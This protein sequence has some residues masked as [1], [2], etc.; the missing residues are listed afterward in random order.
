MPEMLAVPAAAAALLHPVAL[1]QRQCRIADD[2]QN[3]LE[4]LRTQALG[5]NRDAGIDQGPL[6]VVNFEHLAGKRPEIVDGGLR[7]GVAFLG[8]VAEPDDPFRRTPTI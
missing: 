5:I 7:A 6:A 8:A 3:R 4:P 2:R 1:G